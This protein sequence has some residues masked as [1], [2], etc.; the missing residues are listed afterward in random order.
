[1]TS[2]DL[3]ATYLH[4]SDAVVREIYEADGDLWIRFLVPD[5]DSDAAYELE[6]RVERASAAN[7]ELPLDD[8]EEPYD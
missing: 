1:M 7:L 2:I 3:D 8:L 5:T 6:A 4:P